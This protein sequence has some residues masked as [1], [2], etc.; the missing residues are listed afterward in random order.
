ME[1]AITWK[2]LYKE[3]S[4]LGR[5]FYYSTILSLNLLEFQASFLLRFIEFELKQ[6]LKYI[7]SI[8]LLVTSTSF[9]L[10]NM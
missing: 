10:L 8:R 6:N 5:N 2:T 9:S 4:R 1:I 7:E 3:N